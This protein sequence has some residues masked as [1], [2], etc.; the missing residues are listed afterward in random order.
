MGL[1][2]VR[3]GE[4]LLSI[5][6]FVNTIIT[7]HLSLSSKATLNL[8]LEGPSVSPRVFSK[9]VNPLQPGFLNDHKL[10]GKTP[11]RRTLSVSRVESCEIRAYAFSMTRSSE[12]YEFLP[13]VPVHYVLERL[14]QA[15]G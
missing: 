8:E 3:I 9:L 11:S 10:E 15:D 7:T 4:R 6:R 5:S 13:G 1:F 14:M 2:M 12:G